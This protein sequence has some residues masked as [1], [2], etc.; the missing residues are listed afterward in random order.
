V[1][2]VDLPKKTAAHAAVFLCL[3]FKADDYRCAS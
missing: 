1:C 2:C 3:F